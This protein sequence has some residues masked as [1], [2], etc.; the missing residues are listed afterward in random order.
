MHGSTLGQ[1][2]QHTLSLWQQAHM[3]QAH[4]KFLD[5]MSQEQ[6]MTLLP[7]PKHTLACCSVRLLAPCDCRAALTAHSRCCRCWAAV[8]LQRRKVTSAE[9][10]GA[11]GTRPQHVH[12]LAPG[13]RPACQVVGALLGRDARCFQCWPLRSHLIPHH[14][15]HA[16]PD[17][18]RHYVCAADETGLLDAAEL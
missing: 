17:K 14:S 4:H 11:V 5:G 12:Q 7:L 2:V 13:T 3:L 18:H 6:I 10:Y 16:P 15:I 8:R 9:R 1:G